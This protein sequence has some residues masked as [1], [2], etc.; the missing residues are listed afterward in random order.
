MIPETFS[1]LDDFP[2]VPYEAWRALVDKDLRGAPFEKRLVSHTYEGIDI[3]PLYTDRDHDHANDPAGFPGVAPH[4]RGSAPERDPEG[5]WD[6]RQERRE[7]SPDLANARLLDDLRHGVTS[8]LLRFDI[9]GRHALDADDPAAASLAGA[10]GVSISSPDDLAHVFQGVHLGMIGVALEAGEAFLPA[11]ALLLS[12]YRARGVDPGETRIAFNADPLAVLAREGRIGVPLE[13]LYDRMAELATHTARDLPGCTSVRVGTAPYHHAGA[14]AAQDLAFAMAT[15]VEYLRALTA[16]GLTLD[17]ASGQLLFSSAV[18]CQFFLAACKTRAARRL[19]SRVIGASGGRWT[20]MRQ[21]VRTSKRV[22]TTRD[23]WV[24]ILRNVACCFAGAIGG[25][26]CITT[27]P[28]DGAIGHPTELSARIARNTQIILQE[29]VGLARVIDPAGGAWFAERLTDELCAKAWAIFQQIERL[30]GMGEALRTGWVFGQIDSV[31]QARS[32][33]IA[34]R[35]DAITG[36]SEFP[37][38]GEKPVARNDWDAD[39]IRRGNAERVRLFR[40]SRG[41]LTR[42]QDGT[43]TGLIEAAAGGATLG[44]L[45][46]ALPGGEAVELPAPIAPHPYAEAFERLREACDRHHALCGRRPGVSL[47]NLGPAIKHGA[48]SGFSVNFF[49]AGGFRVIQSGAIRD[50]DEAAAFFTGSGER[51]AVL[52]SSDDLYASMVPTIA[53][54]LH[55]AGAAS[56]VLAGRPGANEADWRAAGVDRFIYLKCD[57]VKILGELL[58]ELGVPL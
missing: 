17:E 23:P 57:A 49:G 41:G 50:A 25:A 12:L 8:V 28:F 7:P 45:G 39:A 52:C 40:A 33:A 35:E 3:A 55:R 22:M 14:T 18:G 5:A 13:M 1:I 20:G 51:I 24:N 2:P 53:P 29:E 27:E 10:D 46:R 32:G 15:G 21:H 34:R 54:A 44:D 9:P 56:I 42:I 38:P 36:V 43:M 48:R 30:G 26:D 6:I 4:T 16:R 19:W 58:G 11:S 37:D 31:F 47:V